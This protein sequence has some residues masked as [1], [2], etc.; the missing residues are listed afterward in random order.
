MAAQGR[1]DGTVRVCFHN[2]LVDRIWINGQLNRWIGL[3]GEIVLHGLTIGDWKN[4]S[5]FLKNATA[6]QKKSAKSGRT[7]SAPAGAIDSQ[8]FHLDKKIVAIFRLHGEIRQ[9]RPATKPNPQK[10]S[11]AL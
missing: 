1:F 3:G 10:P 5:G 7:V 6:C 2:A 11:F 9:T 4:V 8:N